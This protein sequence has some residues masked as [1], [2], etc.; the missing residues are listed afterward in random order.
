ML[1]YLIPTR[2]QRILEKFHRY[3]SS[4]QLQRLDT[5][6]MRSRNQVCSNG[7]KVQELIERTPRF[8]QRICSLED[9][10]NIADILVFQSI[11]LPHQ[12]IK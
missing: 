10:Q 11:N 9:I 6:A 2:L 12:Y 8:K 1:K 5:E 4:N 7:T 3:L